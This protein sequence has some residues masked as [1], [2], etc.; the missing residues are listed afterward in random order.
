[1]IKKN[2][3]ITNPQPTKQTNKKMMEA[4]EYVEANGPKAIDA[5]VALDKRRKRRRLSLTDEEKRSKVVVDVA[6]EP[7]NWYTCEFV[8]Q[9]TID[10]TEATDELRDQNFTRRDPE[11]NQ[12]H[13]LLFAN[14]TIPSLDELVFKA[15]HEPWVASEKGY[16]AKAYF[17]MEVISEPFNAQKEMEGIAFAYSYHDG[18][19]EI[20]PRF[21]DT[22]SVFYA[23]GSDLYVYK[24][25]IPV[26]LP[27]YTGREL[28][29]FHKKLTQKQKKYPSESFLF[30]TPVGEKW[31]CD[32]WR[33]D[34]CDFSEES[35]SYRPID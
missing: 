11:F 27:I 10:S 6:F 8:I 2:K 9:A 13:T 20:R 21:L 17:W 14:R 5:V 33:R 1:M 18:N 28:F 34:D 22:V 25:R 32:Y 29:S 16:T 7:D 35:V 15:R 19:G 31:K 12:L 3:K 23:T 4:I 26:Q 24:R 30:D